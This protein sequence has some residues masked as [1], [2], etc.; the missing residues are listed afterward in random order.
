[1][2]PR[3][4]F[5]IEAISP[6]MAWRHDTR[7][8]MDEASLS[9]HICSANGRPIEHPTLANFVAECDKLQ[10]NGIEAIGCPFL[11][12]ARSMTREL[13]SNFQYCLETY[14][15]LLGKQ[16]HIQVR[17][18][19]KLRQMRI[20]GDHVSLTL[21]V[22]CPPMSDV[23]AECAGQVSKIGWRK[24]TQIIKRSLCLPTCSCYFAQVRCRRHE[25]SRRRL[26]I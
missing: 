17:D 11:R 12:V 16:S 3:I 7:R 1:M 19:L 5:D 21:I 25:L 22:E 20:A 24:D 9:G 18:F 10:L 26:R 2:K 8:C 13:S 23:R 6:P 14:A 4:V 15:S